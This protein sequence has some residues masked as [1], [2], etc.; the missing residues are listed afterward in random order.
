VK[1]TLELAILA[2]T[3]VAVVGFGLMMLFPAQVIRLFDSQDR[4]CW[5]WERA[6]YGFR[7]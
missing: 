2:A 5:L 6:P 7:R 3:G 4:S 1:K